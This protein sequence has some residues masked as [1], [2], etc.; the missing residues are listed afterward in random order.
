ME[1]VFEVVGAAELAPDLPSCKT[2]G[3]AGGT[4]GRAADCDWVIPDRRRVLSG[5]HAQVSWRDGAFYLTDT[6]SNGIR[7]KD[8]GASLGKGRPQRIADGCVYCLG[9]I[10]LRARLL[11]D[12]AFEAEVGCPQ[13]AGSLI[14]DDAF[15]ELDP[16]AASQEPAADDFALLGPLAMSPG[17]PH[18]AARIERESLLPPELVAAES[19][20]PPEPAPARQSTDFWERYG[21]VLGIDLRSL[22]DAAR[23]A[24]ALEAAHLLR[25]SV[26]QLQQALRT[27]SELKNELRLA[28]TTIQ[29]AGHNPLKQGADSAEAL[30]L[31]LRDRRPGQ[32]PATQAVSRAFRDLQAHQ[33][34]LLAASRAALGGLLGQF[35]PER[36]IPH[37][38]R[39]RKPLIA[40]AGGRW[41]AY[42]RL[43]RSLER[44]DEW[45]ERLLALDFARTYEEQVRLIAT[46]DTDLQG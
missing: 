37:F 43:H 35:A 12:T 17:Q 16:L 7:I 40:T 25:H 34:A 27:R 11:Q 22:D 24:L 21:A 33:V 5:H 38:E 14:P 26:G 44:D 23:E 32:L 45:R 9:G 28:Q 19:E 42:C 6:S 2:F 15:L 30:N 1:L 41:R 18:D 20:A 3:R 31:L 36:L 10:E 8:S 29:G 39:E 46:L 4:I 13:A